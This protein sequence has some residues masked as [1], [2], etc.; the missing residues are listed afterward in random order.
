MAGVRI[1]FVLVTAGFPCQGLSG[2]NAT[3]K[4]FEDDRSQLFYEGRRVVQEV[5]AEKHQL[6]FLF[7]NVAS[8]DAADRDYVS[9]FLGVRPSVSCASGIRRLD[10]SVTS[11]LHGG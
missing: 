6:E 8:M 10:A 5:K 4:G 9:H 3:Q 7:E 1:L 2:A 11:G